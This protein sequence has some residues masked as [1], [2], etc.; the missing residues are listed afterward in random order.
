MRSFASST[1]W[2]TTRAEQVG[3]FSGE[4]GGGKSTIELMKDVAHVA[5]KDW[6][7]SLPDYGPAI[8]IG[9]E[10]SEKELHIRMAAIAG[11]FNVSFQD[12]IKSGLKI[13]PLLDSDDPTPLGSLLCTISKGG[14]IELT[15]LY[16]QIYEAVGDIKPIN[17]SIDPLSSVFGGSELDRAQ[18][19]AFRWHMVRLARVSRTK[20]TN[21]ETYGGSI[22][23]LSHPSLQGISSGSGISGSTAWH[24]AFRFRQYLKGVTAE[25]GEVVD[26]DLR[27]LEFKKNQYGPL[28]ETIVLRYR[29]GLFLPIPGVTGLNKLSRELTA[30]D[31]F[32]TL[33]RRFT[34]ANRN[35]SERLG[36]SR[37]STC[38]TK[39]MA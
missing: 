28:G 27:Q 34:R 24:G 19:Y 20:R 25:N 39:L 16:H 7:G 38:E 9:T 4:G 31:V 32:L 13:L 22:T 18:V 10:E 3:I 29:A 12:L 37:F 2:R 23:I 8:Y 15:P 14:T 6:L 35:V 5:G 11:H 26:K 17:V 36:L 30:Q 21:G 33:L 1:H